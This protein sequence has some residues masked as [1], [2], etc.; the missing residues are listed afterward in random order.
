MRGVDANLALSTD[1]ES[2][3]GET[4]SR[5]EKIWLVTGGIVNKFRFRA[6]CNVQY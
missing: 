1:S 4:D 3:G 6:S 5:R 2:Q